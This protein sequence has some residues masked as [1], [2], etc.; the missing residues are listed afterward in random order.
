M[1]IASRLFSLPSLTIAGAVEYFVVIRLWPEYLGSH[2]R[3]TAVIG[4][5]LANYVFGIIFWA[6]L[7]PNLISPLRRIPGPRVSEAPWHSSDR[8]LTKPSVGS[9]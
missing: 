5:I 9:T 7:Y 3:F 8:V 1:T 4:T 2:S 6:L